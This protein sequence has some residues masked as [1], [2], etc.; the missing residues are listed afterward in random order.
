MTND[1]YL[2]K[3]AFV[4]KTNFITATKKYKYYYFDNI[5]PPDIANALNFFAKL[6][7]LN[8]QSQL[9]S[10]L[11]VNFI[12]ALGVMQ[13]GGGGYKSRVS[14]KGGVAGDAPINE[15]FEEFEEFE[16][17]KRYI[18]ESIYLQESKDLFI[19]L[20]P[21]QYDEPQIKMV[22][23]I[24][25]IRIDQRT[26]KI[27]DPEKSL[28]LIYDII[29]QST[30]KL[31]RINIEENIKE[32]GATSYSIQLIKK[33]VANGEILLQIN[34]VSLEE[35]HTNY[36]KIH[37]I[38]QDVLSLFS[39]NEFISNYDKYDDEPISIRDIELLKDLDGQELTLANATKYLSDFLNRLK[40]IHDKLESKLEFIGNILKDI[41]KSRY[42]FN[43]SNKFID[44]LT[45]TSDANIKKIIDK[46]KDYE[47]IY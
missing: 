28:N 2:M 46:Y 26:N 3:L 20:K 40:F 32:T 10:V 37:S 23:S 13:D 19:N 18:Q 45:G 6:T 43:P 14:S 31:Y 9:Q 7:I 35:L 27:K 44:S 12:Q 29:K 17:F 15:E 47:N 25:N 21:P 41:L 5:R 8:Y 22:S 4:T 34:V 36:E 33:N 1:T 42:V 11:G 16:A 38:F 39:I 30:L 24:L